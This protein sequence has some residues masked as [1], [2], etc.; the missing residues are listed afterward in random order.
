LG[1]EVFQPQAARRFDLADVRQEF[2]FVEGLPRP[3]ED[4]GRNALA[5]ER[6]GVIGLVGFHGLLPRGR[7]RHYRNDTAPEGP[8]EGKRAGLRR[9]WART[10]TARSGIVFGG[11]RRK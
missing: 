4:F 6:L 5:R 8:A 10:S 1:D 11:R 3:F 2:I 7:S 9:R